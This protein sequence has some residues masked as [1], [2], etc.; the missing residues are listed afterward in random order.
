MVL[1]AHRRRRSRG[2]SQTSA[3]S[4]QSYGC[5]RARIGRCAP[6]YATKGCCRGLMQ[7]RMPS[8]TRCLASASQQLS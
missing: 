4:A 2:S 3:L 8:V 1:G 6:A 5:L 7:T